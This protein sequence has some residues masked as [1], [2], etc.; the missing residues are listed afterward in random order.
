MSSTIDVVEEEIGKSRYYRNTDVNYQVYRCLHTGTFPE[1]KIT[2]TFE[3][4]YTDCIYGCVAI[5]EYDVE[6][7]CELSQ[8]EEGGCWFLEWNLNLNVEDQ[9]PEEVNE[10]SIK[11]Y[12]RLD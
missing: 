1:L 7:A 11:I 10:V 12:T 6:Y 9:I 2:F 5:P 4:G 3:D 8:D